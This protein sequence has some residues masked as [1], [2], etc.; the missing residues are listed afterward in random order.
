MTEGHRDDEAPK[1]V[2]REPVT[3]HPHY[4]TTWLTLGEAA[5]LLGVS[6][7]TVQ[8]RAG[9]GDLERDEE[10]SLYRCRDTA[11]IRGQMSDTSRCDSDVSRHVA[12]TCRDTE[13]KLQARVHELERAN[14]NLEASLMEAMSEL[15]AHRART[16]MSLSRQIVYVVFLSLKRWADAVLSRHERDVSRRSRSE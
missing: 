7:R 14:E 10:R 3:L 5:D 13:A 16:R 12:A 2:P 1:R 11:W 6:P 8:R 9:S 4:T 15:E